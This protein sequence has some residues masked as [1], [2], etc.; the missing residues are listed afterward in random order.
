LQNCT[1]IGQWQDT[2]IGQAPCLVE[3]TIDGDSIT[4]TVDV[5]DLKAVISGVA[6]A[7][8]KPELVG[9]SPELHRTE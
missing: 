2:H 5:L 6:S 8:T 7:F 1:A 4:V 9:M 3:K